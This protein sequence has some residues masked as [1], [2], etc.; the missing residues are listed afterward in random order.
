MT[1]RRLTLLLAIAALAGGAAAT[2]DAAQS[3]AFIATT[4]YS[5]GFLSTVAF[6]P[7][8][9]A[10]NDVRSISSDA[11]VRWHGGLVY[12]VN[13]FNHDNI[14]VLDPA[15]GY[16]VVRQFSVGNG[17]NP[18]D[19]EFASASK[20]FVTRYELDDLLVVNPATGAV[21]DSIP[22]APFADADGIPEMSRMAIRGGRLFVALQRLDRNDFY[23]PA[24][25]SQIVVVDVATHAVLDANPALPGTQGVLLPAQNPKTELVVDA[26]GRLVVGCAGAFGLLD[27]AVVRLDPATLAVTTEITEG[28]LGGDLNDVATLDAVRGFVVVN[29]A[30]FATVLKSYRR[31]LATAQTVLASPGFDLA[32]IEIN[33]R[34]ELWVC[35]R[36]IAN[37]G[38]RVFDAATH[39]PLTPSP[40]GTGLP[41]FDI[42]FDGAP[43]PVAVEGAAGAP[44]GLA[45]RGAWP[46][47][48][49]G[50]VRLG[51]ALGAAGGDLEVEIVDVAGR[52][53]WST[54]V[55]APG[56][57]EH[58]VAW[59]GRTVRGAAAPAG[60]YVV[61]ARCG[62]SAATGRV[63]RI[64]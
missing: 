7:P 13:R 5:T 32:D 16:A 53:C 62:P 37:P 51:F 49:R 17:S 59:D 22:L 15:A 36:R 38:V 21:L 61:R 27:G 11:V 26:G 41:P 29:D 6:G 28:A 1:H 56:A 40:I 42:A 14:Q 18:Q 35:D 10:S 30:S 64:R 2:A 58:G 8:R 43:G 54:V 3:R 50:A 9:V 23:A 12:V 19:I 52:R 24:G 46:N 55:R 60:L 39:A 57:G 20:A 33:D 25:G 47:P 63:L 31:D 34:G 48:S 4:D 45:F 44:V